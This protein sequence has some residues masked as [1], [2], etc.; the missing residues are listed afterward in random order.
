MLTT[1]VLLALL[2]NPDVPTMATPTDRACPFVVI[3]L[4]GG[5]IDSFDKP[6]N[7]GKMASFRACPGGKTVT[8]PAKDVDWAATEKANAPRVVA[9]PTPNP[10]REVSGLASGMKT[11]TVEEMEKR[12]KEFGQLRTKTGKVVAIDSDYYFAGDSVAQ[13]L[14]ASRLVANTTGCP[15]GQMLIFGSVTNVSRLKLRNL[16]GAM[17][18]LAVYRDIDLNQK[19][20]VLAE[21]IQSLEPADLMP[22]EGA[23]LM[24]Q[25]PCK[26]IWR[27]LL[28]KQ[29]RYQDPHYF[30][31]QGLVYTLR[32]IGGKAETLA[33]P[34]TE[35]F[36]MGT[37]RPKEVSRTAPTPTPGRPK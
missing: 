6:R 19:S 22:G 12:H 21:Q 11:Q 10:E 30:L 28:T 20:E 31:S 8:Y 5:P 17:Q 36:P 29:T 3:T 14:R 13:H 33:S 32:D 18:I 7:T 15:D 24:V 23:D 27:G 35:P 37:P 25:I 2:Q 34:D 1:A 4:S 26:T 16:R 9:A